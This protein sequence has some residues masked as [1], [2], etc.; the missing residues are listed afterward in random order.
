MS[1]TCSSGS[2]SVGFAAFG[3]LDASGEEDAALLARVCLNLPGAGEGDTS[4]CGR[5]PRVERGGRSGT[6][7]SFQVWLPGGLTWR[8]M[9]VFPK[10]IL[11]LWLLGG[12][13]YLKAIELR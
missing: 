1:L 5:V 12:I 11:V 4:E 3:D 9:S 2:V 10:L 8:Y 7:T 13:R 6:G